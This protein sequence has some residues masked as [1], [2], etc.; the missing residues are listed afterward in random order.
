MKET[1]SIPKRSPSRT[2]LASISRTLESFYFQ[3]R[4]GELDPALFDGWFAQY[5]DL[6]ANAGAEQFWRLRKHQYGADFVAFVDRER[7]ARS[8]KPLY[9][10]EVGG[11]EG[12]GARS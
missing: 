3:S 11:H 10:V 2:V 7:N 12:E 1:D 5:L 8:A 4:N 6:H 9:A